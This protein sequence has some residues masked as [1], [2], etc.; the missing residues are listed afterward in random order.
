LKGVVLIEAADR[1]K[2]RISPESEGEF[3]GDLRSRFQL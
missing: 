2:Y 1:H 3:I